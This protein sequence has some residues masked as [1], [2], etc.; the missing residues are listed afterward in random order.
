MNDFHQNHAASL[1]TDVALFWED[2][3]EVCKTMRGIDQVNAQNLL[4]RI[5]GLKIEDLGLK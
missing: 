2:L 5:G 1:N 3:L 4:R